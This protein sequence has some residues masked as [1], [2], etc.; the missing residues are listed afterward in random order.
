M[1]KLQELFESEEMQT[2]ME[3]N[4]ELINETN[5]S[6]VAFVEGLKQYVY[7][8]PTLFLEADLQDMY[9]NIRIFSEAATEQ[10]LHEI[11]TLNAEKAHI[12]EPIT[13]ENALNDYL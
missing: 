2:F 8:N 6:T 12:I 13:P 7:D 4:Q 10:F 11:T 1:S 5:E 3:A 9:K